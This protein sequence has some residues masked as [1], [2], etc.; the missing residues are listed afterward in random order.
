MPQ[1]RV[2]FPNQGFRTPNDDQAAS[3]TSKHR[4]RTQINVACNYCRSRKHKCSG[5]RPVC[6]ACQDRGRECVYEADPDSTRAVTLKRTHAVLEQETQN[7]RQLVEL[8]RTRPRT[9]IEAIIRQLREGDDVQTAI[10]NADAAV[11]RLTGRLSGIEVQW[12]LVVAGRDTLRDLVRS[13]F[14][15]LYPVIPP[16]RSAASSRTSSTCSSKDRRM[17]IRNLLATDEPDSRQQRIHGVTTPLT[18]GFDPA[19]LSQLR[20][21]VDDRL[22]AVEPR[23]WTTVSVSQ[24]EMANMLSVYL[25]WHHTEYRLFDE[26]AFI[27]DLL[28]GDTEYCSQLLVN[29][30]CSFVATKLGNHDRGRTLTLRQAFIE[31]AI[32]LWTESRQLFTVTVVS[33]ACIL[34]LSD[35]FH[36]NETL[37]TNILQHGFYVAGRLGIF[38]ATTA[39]EPT[40]S[41]LQKEYKA[42]AIAGWGCYRVC[43]TV[44]LH[45]LEGPDCSREPSLP[46]I[47]KDVA[48]VDKWLSW[49]RSSDVEESTPFST[50]SSFASCSLA[51]LMSDHTSLRRYLIDARLAGRATSEVVS[52]Q[53]ATLLLHNLTQW[54]DSLHPQL[55][56]HASARP[57]VLGMHLTAHKIVLESFRPFVGR[58][59]ISSQIY[60]SSLKQMTELIRQS[61]RQW[62]RLPNLSNAVGT[63]YNVLYSLT[64][65]LEMDREAN[66]SFLLVAEILRHQSGT[67]PMIAGLLRYVLS[68]A[69]EKGARLPPEADE[70]LQKLLV[71]EDD[72]NPDDKVN[73]SSFSFIADLDMLYSDPEA[74][75]LRSSLKRM[76]DGRIP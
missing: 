28:S 12:N 75:T 64:P 37:S 52:L 42:K 66:E 58:D 67:N 63:L 35:Y 38:S 49:P 71:E 76:K 46:A 36:T 39:T 73:A 65:F 27:Q 18:T 30:I 15:S 9:N 44:A 55:Q 2:L 54:A 19:S 24:I 7:L 4:K 10:G 6:A 50:S 74:A 68:A 25:C 13:N 17:T 47:G 61:H 14:K 23:L 51:R 57:F 53:M 26:D 43:T 72:A 22:A 41:A 21:L 56:C 1:Q 5:E 62:G 11:E 32:R 20:P 34:S 69:V 31:E 48:D 59:R 3:E 33:A 29:S 8:L 60:T 70:I 45:V 40:T 16:G